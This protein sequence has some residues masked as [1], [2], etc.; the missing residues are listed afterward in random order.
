MSLIDPLTKNVVNWIDMIL[1]TS[2]IVEASLHRD[3]LRK[4][5]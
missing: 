3:K 5:R 2:N 4:R 1:V